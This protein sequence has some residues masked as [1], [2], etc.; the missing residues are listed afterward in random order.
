[1]TQRFFARTIKPRKWLALTLSYNISEGQKRRDI[2]LKLSNCIVKL[3]SV[4]FGFRNTILHAYISL[5]ECTMIILTKTGCL[6][7]KWDASQKDRVLQRHN[8]VKRYFENKQ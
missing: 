8:S 5:T 7:T 2:T 1:M 3:K 4:Y 6:Y